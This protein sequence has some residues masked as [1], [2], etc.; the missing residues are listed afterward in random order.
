MADQIGPTVLASERKYVPVEV[1]DRAFAMLDEMREKRDF[2][3]ER[4]DRAEMVARHWI[5]RCEELEEAIEE[6]RLIG[7]GPFWTRIAC[8]V[9]A[10]AIIVYPLAHMAGRGVFGG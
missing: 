3:A 8:A 4:A 10:T 2:E 9:I 1:V 7:P 5:D 6:G